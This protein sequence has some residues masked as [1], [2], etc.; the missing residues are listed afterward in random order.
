MNRFARAGAVFLAITL[1]STLV[2]AE[3]MATQ[4][5][6]N[7]DR[8][9]CKATGVAADFLVKCQKPGEKGTVG[10]DWVVGEGAYAPN[11]AGLASLGLVDAYTA[12][13]NQAYLDAAIKYAKGLLARKASFSRKNLPYKSD[14]EL[15]VRLATIQKD[16]A[17][18][19]AARELFDIVRSRSATGAKEVARIAAGRKQTPSLLGFDTALAIRAAAVLG[20]KRYGYQLADA[21]VKRTKSWYRVKK[22]PRYSL[23][24]AA[25]LVVALEELDAGHYAKTINRFRTRILGHQNENGSWLQNETQATAY[26]VMALK[27]SQLT[28]EREAAAKGATWLK[29]TMLK[30]GSFAT[31]NDYMPEPFVGRVISEVN[32]EALSALAMLCQNQ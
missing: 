12:T 4:Y 22:D 24:S 19:K 15:L 14:I 8:D 30:E 7:L 20:E 31:Y 21:V 23:I 27:G 3:E 16:D 25:A 18:N 9:V 11:V 2:W 32:A 5:K 28:A 29:S 17:Y 6:A 10:W 13:S 1:V 26:A